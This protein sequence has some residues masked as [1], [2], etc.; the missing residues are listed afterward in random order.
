MLVFRRHPLTG[1]I[2]QQHVLAPSAVPEIPNSE[3]SPGRA[4]SE[5]VPRGDELPATAMAYPAR[6]FESALA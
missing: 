6:E 1:K 2:I 5:D 4:L 3:L